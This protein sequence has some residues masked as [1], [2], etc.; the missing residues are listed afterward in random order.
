MKRDDV[1]GLAPTGDLGLIDKSSFLFDSLLF[2]PDGEK[3]KIKL[4]VKQQP[5]VSEVH[6]LSC[7]PRT[8]SLISILSL[9]ALYSTFY[10]LIYPK[11]SMSYV[12]ISSK[13]DDGE[14]D[15]H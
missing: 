6:V 14:P 9:K 10:T 8:I 1:T 3:E 11:S 7:V 13:K 15:S 4:S 2:G 5:Q 12:N